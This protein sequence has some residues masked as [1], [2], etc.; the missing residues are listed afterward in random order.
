[1]DMFIL[2]INTKTKFRWSIDHS[3]E[4][5]MKRNRIEVLLL[6]QTKRVHTCTGL[7]ARGIICGI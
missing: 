7:K 1:M 2:F 3:G 6:I 4:D 5:T